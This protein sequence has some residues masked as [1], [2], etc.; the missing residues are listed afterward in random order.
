MN[1]TMESEQ[2]DTRVSVPNSGPIW[3]EYLM[4]PKR[5]E[6][7]KFVPSRIGN[8]TIIGEVGRGSQGIVKCVKDENGKK[9]AMKIFI[10]AQPFDDDSRKYNMCF[11]P[12]L[13]EMDH[14]NIAKILKFVPKAVET[15]EGEI[16]GTEV[17]YLLQEFVE[18]A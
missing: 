18:D 7:E 17:A 2:I 6:S 12:S 14:K 11:Q 9:F 4:V 3:I 8:Y 13:L 16:G 10:L 1:Q 5:E 15:F